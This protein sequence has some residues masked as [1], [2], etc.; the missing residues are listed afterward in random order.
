MLPDAPPG[1]RGP[2]SPRVRHVTVA[3]TALATALLPVV[4]GVLLARTMATDPMA[5]VNALITSG[6]QR[7]RVSRAE[8][9]SCGHRALRRIPRPRGSAPGAGGDGGGRRTRLR[10]RVPVPTAGRR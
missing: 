10:G 9:R 5:P 4:V 7:A 8:L 3:G 2:R 1:L 6:G